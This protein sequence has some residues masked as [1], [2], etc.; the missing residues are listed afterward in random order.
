M[1]KRLEEMNPR[2]PPYSTK[3]PELA[4]LDKYYAGDGGVPPEGN[5]VEHNVCW[6]GKWMDVG[7][8]AKMEM[9]RVAGNLTDQD[10]L[11]VDAAGGDFRLR[12]ASPAVA[13]ATRFRCRRSAS[14]RMST[15]RCFRHVEALDSR[16]AWPHDVARR[17]G[18]AVAMSRE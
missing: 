4:E 12:P 6:G 14:G 13:A 1:K 15:G 8:N 17:G 11:F 5:V 18:Q 7:W 16:L 2:Q 9:I 3:Y 10:P